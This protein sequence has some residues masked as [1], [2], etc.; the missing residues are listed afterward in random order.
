M[1][2]GKPM[3]STAAPAVAV[4]RQPIV[5]RTGAV[6]GY[7]LL[8]RAARADAPL[9][10]GEQ[11]TA[12]VVLGA[13]TIGV[14]QLVGD[15]VIF[16][17]AERGVLTGETPVSLPPART[18]IEVL[19]TVAVDDESV[20]GCRDLVGRGYQLALDDFVWVDGAERLLELATIVK[21]DVLALGREGSLALA[22]RCRPYGVRLLAEKLETL[23]DLDWAMQAGFELFQGYAIEKPRVVRGQAIPAAALAHTQLATTLLTEDVDFD[24]LE[25]ILRREPGLVLQVLQ[26]ASV[27]AHHGLRREVRSIRDALVILGTG[28]IRQWVALTL[29]SG[30]PGSGADGLATALVRARTCELL[31]AERSV[32][33][34]D[35]AFT[36]GLL[37]TLDLLLGLPL[38][39][40]SGMLDVPPAVADAA[41]RRSTAAGELV[42]EV[43]AFQHGV[44]EGL[45]AATAVDLDAAAARAFAWA[46]P[47]VNGMSGSVA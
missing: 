8:Y 35:F 17:N 20:R 13:L 12:D 22:A 36:V 42:T 21:L 15:K 38:E 6:V 11:M 41:F 26:L 44:V 46:M 2:A 37:S 34:P 14:G 3:T 9:P 31:A 10:S 40:V 43:E 39:D 24:A 18:V 27:G 32:C 7:E 16:C 28:R 19:E 33:D 5:D 47:Y 29:L 45:P 1:A 4:G 23:D 30:R 25:S